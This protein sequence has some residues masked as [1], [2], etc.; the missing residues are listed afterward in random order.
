MDLKFSDLVNVISEDMTKPTDKWATSISGRNMGAQQLNIVDLLRQNHLD[1]HP[2]KVKAPVGMPH[3]TQ[4][5][6]QLLGD[7]YLQI[8]QVKVAVKIAHENPI[9]DERP[10]A[11][12]A[13]EN[14]HAKL[15][16]A[17]EFVQ[18]VGTDIDDFTIDT[19]EKEK[20]KRLSKDEKNKK[21][22]YH[23]KLKALDKRSK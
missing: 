3:S 13:L 18:A 7:L 12:E 21:D 20:P 11:K 1:Q 8:E 2:N 17:E 5:L 10:Q 9:L 19:S 23:K 16:K 22:A 14:M 4:N 15:E 6:L